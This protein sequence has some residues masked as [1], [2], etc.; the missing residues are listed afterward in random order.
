MMKR[1]ISIL[2]FF[3]LSGV[4]CSAAY[5]QGNDASKKIMDKLSFFE[6]NYPTE[7]AYLQFD[8]PYYATGDTIYFKAYVT[9][10][11]QHKLSGLSGVLHVELINTKNKV[12]QSIK[13]KLDSGLAWGDFALP[14]SL[15][16][17]NYRIRAYTQWMRN[18]NETGFFEKAFAVGSSSAQKIPESGAKQP[19]SG[20][21]PDV[22]FFPE[23][24]SMAGGRAST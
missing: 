6:A 9:A 7:K 2:L 18:F 12:D 24:G 16:A 20:L 15:P 14:D 11:G 17:G 5:A 22:R 1:T 19:F 10:G 4:I 21:K 3:S 8:K 23:G 13:L